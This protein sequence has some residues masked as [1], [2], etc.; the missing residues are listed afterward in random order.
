MKYDI[1]RLSFGDKVKINIQTFS[2]FSAKQEED[3][4]MLESLSFPYLCNFF[5]NY[6][7]LLRAVLSQV[8]Q[9]SSILLQKVDCCT[10]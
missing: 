6:S 9:A 3:I 10:L 8:H 2:K 7:V 1:V 5:K 4:T